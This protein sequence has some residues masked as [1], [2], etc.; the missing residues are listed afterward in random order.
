MCSSDLQLNRFR[1]SSPEIKLCYVWENGKLTFAEFVDGQWIRGREAVYGITQAPLEIHTNAWLV[2]D[3][4][5][6]I[7][8]HLST[9]EKDSENDTL[10]TQA[11][12]R[13]GE[14][15]IPQKEGGAFEYSDQYGLL[16]KR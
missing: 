4:E 10:V 11:S 2:R 9:Q 12:Y 3:Y 8:E 6:V 16:Q 1:E 5:M 15:S 14:L 13:Y 7:R